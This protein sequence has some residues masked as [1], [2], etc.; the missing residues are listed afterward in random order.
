M[1]KWFDSYLTGRC[2]NIVINGKTSEIAEIGSG[3]PQGSVLVPWLF[4]MYTQPLGKIIQK[5]G[6]C[7]DQYADDLQVYTS[8]KLQQDVSNVI[9]KI[10]NCLVDMNR[11]LQMNGLMLNSEKT[12][13]D[14]LSSFR[15]QVGSSFIQPKISVHNLGVTL[16]SSL[17]MHKHV[18]LVTRSCYMHLRNFSRIRTKDTA[19]SQVHASIISRLDYANSLMFWIS[20]ASL[21]KLQKVQNYAARL[22]C[23]VKIRQH[24]TPYLKQLH[25]LPVRSRL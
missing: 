21:A 4:T 1:L 24:I 20:E 3:V 2:Q 23:G 15:I 5:H 9:S 18:S 6:L 22:I 8:F 11:W 17:S 19:K 14:S 16:D 7:Y 25:W 13:V 10:E 12:E